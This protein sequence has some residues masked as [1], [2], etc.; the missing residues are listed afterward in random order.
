MTDVEAL[1]TARAPLAFRDEDGEIV[2]S[3]VAAV[4]DAVQ[5]NDA[6]I[7]RAL[8]SDLHEADQG[9]LLEALEADLRPRLIGLLGDDFDTSP[10]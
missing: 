5:R 9:A 8:V 1:S 10:P 7:A 6:E 2:P 3:F 4:A